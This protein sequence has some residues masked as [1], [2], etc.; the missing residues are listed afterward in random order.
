MDGSKRVLVCTACG[1]KEEVGSGE[2]A[3]HYKA[4]EKSAEKVLTTRTVSK[5]TGRRLTKEEL[6]QMKEEYYEFV[7]DQMG[8]YGD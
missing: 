8:E 2:L 7:L 5:A 1:Y 3:R 4:T 6:E